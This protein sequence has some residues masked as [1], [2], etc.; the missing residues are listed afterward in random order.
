MI[1]MLPPYHQQHRG[2]SLR[3][4]EFSCDKNFAGEL[5]NY[6]PEI[7]HAC[8]VCVSK[9]ERPYTPYLMPSASTVDAPA[10]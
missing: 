8:L 1:D 7:L 9:D 4:R 6:H 3:L 5:K 10:A 2:R